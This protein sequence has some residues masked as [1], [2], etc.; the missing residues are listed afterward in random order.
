MGANTVP[1]SLVPVVTFVEAL[2]LK[3]P[4]ETVRLVI[5]SKMRVGVSKVTP[6]LRAPNSENEVVIPQ[7]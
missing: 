2:T 7:I 1:L 3:S 6:V 4:L 5:G